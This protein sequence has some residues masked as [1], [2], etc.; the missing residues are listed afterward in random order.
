MV[1]SRY[2]SESN[3]PVER[4]CHEG[5]H[6]MATECRQICRYKAED[7][8]GC[9]NDANPSLCYLPLAG[10][11]RVFCDE[12]AKEY[13]GLVQ[14]QVWRAAGLKNV[15]WENATHAARSSLHTLTLRQLVRD[16]QA[17]KQL[18]PPTIR[19]TRNCDIRM[20]EDYKRKYHDFLDGM[21]L[22]I[23][24]YSLYRP[25][26]SNCFEVFVGKIMAEKLSTGPE[27]GG[28]AKNPQATWSRAT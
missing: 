7:G 11:Q 13:G 4:A 9:S 18:R 23:P 16:K 26:A 14:M 3:P 25:C 10:R 20:I 12:H 8:S 5:W 19:I 15:V 28:P 6:K 27:A 21:N 1:I 22:R 24:Y 2:P 17:N